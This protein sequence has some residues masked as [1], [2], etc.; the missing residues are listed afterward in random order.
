MTKEEL[1]QP[2]AIRIFMFSF[3]REVRFISLEIISEYLRVIGIGT[4]SKDKELVPKP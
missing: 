2:K 3:L 4:L 1:N